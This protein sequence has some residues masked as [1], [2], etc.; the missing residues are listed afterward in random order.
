MKVLTLPSH[1]PYASNTYFLVL[2][3]EGCVIDPSTPY[4]EALLPSATKYILLTHSHFDHILTINN[5]VEATG[6][7][8][9][10]FNSELS[11]LSDPEKNCYS[12]FFGKRDGYFGDA[13]PLHDND[14]IKL[15]GESIRVMHTPIASRIASRITRLSSTLAPSI[16]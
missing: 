2:G 7:K 14:V 12:I 8:V 15:G 4:D 13:T 5:W 10:I 1:L 6:A 3:N 11:F 9:C 16:S